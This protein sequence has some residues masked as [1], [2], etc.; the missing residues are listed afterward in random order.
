[1]TSR[2]SSNSEIIT[3]DCLPATMDQI[4]MDL[5]GFDWP[6]I[7]VAL[8]VPEALDSDRQLSRLED[9]ASAIRGIARMSWKPVDRQRLWNFASEAFL[10]LAHRGWKIFLAMEPDQ[11]LCIL[12]SKQEGDPG[13][14]TAV[15]HIWSEGWLDERRALDYKE[16]MKLLRK[17]KR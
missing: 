6:Q 7:E 11:V 3:V 9:F 2:V 4:W 10:I 14:S 8:D 16:G 12:L 5:T 17:L 15:Q 1:M 13:L